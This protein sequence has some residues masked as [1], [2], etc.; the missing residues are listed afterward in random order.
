LLDRLYA[1]ETFGIK[2]GLENISRLCAALGHPEQAFTSIHVAGTNGKGSVAAMVHAGLVA[3]GVRAGRFISPHL[4]D[5][6]ERFVIGSDPVSADDLQRAV[7]EVLDRADALRTSGTL[8]VHPTFFEAT[9]AVAFELFRRAQVEIAVIEVGL[10]G[11]FDSTNVVRAPIGAIT[12]VGFDHQDLLGDTLEAIALEKAGIIKPG[13]T[14]VTGALPDEARAVITAV[15]R[16]RQAQLVEAANG[17]R[18]EG[19]LRDGRGTV[20]MVTPEG[21][22]GPITLALRGEHQ[23]RNALVAVR[24]LEALRRT[25]VRVPGEA[26]ERGLTEV[27][28]PGRLELI[29]VQEGPQVLLD[30]AHNVDG[31]AALA[32]YLGR[33]HPERPTLVIGV[34]RDKDVA[35]IVGALLPMVSSVIATAADTPRA[36]PA[37]DL[38]TRI[39]AAGAEIPVRAEPDP[40]TAV[41]DALAAGQTVCVTGSIYLV[42]AVRDRLRRRAILR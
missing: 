40:V 5:L 6:S 27:D 14:V 32:A 11:R 29:Q 18:V 41:E 2:L 38:A 26:I 25:G 7:D 34:M 3:A 12:S 10:G 42:G 30:A 23:I 33:W 21:R 1:L 22:Y 37:R 20:T 39:A 15:A 9:T 31:A 16:E 4:V 17:A 36:L 28:W 19:E 13:M 35:G 8:A 24:L